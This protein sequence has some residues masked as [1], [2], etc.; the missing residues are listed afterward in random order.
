M[1]TEFPVSEKIYAQLLHAFPKAHRECYGAA[2]A[3]LFRD[4]CRDAWTDAGN[5]GLLKLWL[6]A[7]PDLAGSSI[8]ERLAALKERKTMNDKLADLSAFQNYSPEKTFVRVFVV[9]FLIVVVITTAVTFLLPQMYASQSSVLVKMMMTKNNTH[10]PPSG[11]PD[12]MKSQCE[13]IASDTVLGPVV[14]KLNLN[15]TWGEKYGNGEE[16][17][18]A[19]SLTLLRKRLSVKSVRNSLVASILVFSEDKNEAA[20][21][22]NAISDSYANYRKEVDQ[23][24]SQKFQAKLD[25]IIRSPLS[26]TEKSEAF[27]KI[28]SDE[29]A[30]YTTPGN[31]MVPIVEK[32]EPAKVPSRPNKPLNITIGVVGGILLASI[33]GALVLVVKRFARRKAMA[34]AV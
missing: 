22:A 16:F 20:A 2:M 10:Q 34:S 7:L 12:L 5:F 23:Q 6:R 4:Q 9:V 30:A 29:V 3:Q 32:A 13:I 18:T 14:Q 19:Q 11:D 15:K 1:K 33:V 31:F 17:T 25:G 26:D 8:R 21:I 28:Q 24:V 27:K